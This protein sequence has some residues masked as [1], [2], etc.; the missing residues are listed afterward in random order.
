M[1]TEK[2]LFASASVNQ[3]VAFWKL[4][5]CSSSIAHYETENFVSTPIN[6]EVLHL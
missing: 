6:Q 2:F 5:D 3:Q 1:L 4:H